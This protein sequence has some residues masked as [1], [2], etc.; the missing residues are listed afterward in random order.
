MS[1]R[2][3][4]FQALIVLVVNV[5]EFIIYVAAQITIKV[6]SRQMVIKQQIIVDELF[7]K[8]TI[9]M[10]QYLTKSI[11][12]RITVLN[13]LP[14]L[15]DMV[16]PLLPDKHGP[17]FQANLTERFLVLLNEMALQRLNVRKLL[18]GVW[19][20]VNHTIEGDRKSVV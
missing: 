18:F 11:V 15:L 13:V 12:S 5:L 19:A 14:Q 8:I 2:E 1:L 3:M 4:N 9:W 17:T 10:R 6:I 20:V 7:A 16:Q